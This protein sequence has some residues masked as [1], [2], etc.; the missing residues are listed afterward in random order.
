MRTIN[1]I[2]KE[3]SRCKPR[4]KNNFYLK[5]QQNMKTG[6]PPG[7]GLNKASEKYREDKIKYQ[8]H[9]TYRNKYLRDQIKAGV[10]TL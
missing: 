6:L 8:N 7:R 4:T 3:Y 9:Q 2:N 10:D 5:R 1:R